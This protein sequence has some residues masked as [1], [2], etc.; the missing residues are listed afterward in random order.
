MLPIFFL[1]SA[2]TL[3][4]AF[5]FLAA[6]LFRLYRFRFEKDLFS[7]LPARFCYNKII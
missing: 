5:F 1:F 2:S 4:L 7:K 6:V 3:A